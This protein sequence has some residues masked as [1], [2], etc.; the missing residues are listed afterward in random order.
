M[1]SGIPGPNASLSSCHDEF[2]SRA[3]DDY[4]VTYLLAMVDPET[5]DDD[6]DIEA[7]REM[8]SAYVPAVNQIAE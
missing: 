2:H 1:D 5:V 3:I 4:L 6:F 8:L 7:L